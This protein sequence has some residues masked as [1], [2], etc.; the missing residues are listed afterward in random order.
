M[1]MT[2]WW[3]AARQINRARQA[4]PTPA[5]ADPFSRV[6][7]PRPIRWFAYRCDWCGRKPAWHFDRVPV[8]ETNMPDWQQQRIPASSPDRVTVMPMNVCNKCLPKV[9][10]WR[11]DWTTVTPVQGRIQE[12]VYKMGVF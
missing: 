4:A 1:D 3:H 11:F 9:V 6:S 7:P 10:R 2:R 8:L 5:G 12:Y